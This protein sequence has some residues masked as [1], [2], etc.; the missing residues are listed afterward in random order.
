[1]TLAVKPFIHLIQDY[2]RFYIGS[3]CI[4]LIFKTS[5]GTLHTF[6]HLAQYNTLVFFLP[7]QKDAMS[8]YWSELI[9]Q[10]DRRQRGVH[11]LRR[12]LQSKLHQ[13][14]PAVDSINCWNKTR[15]NCNQVTFVFILFESSALLLPIL[16]DL[17]IFFPLKVKSWWR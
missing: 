17:L 7:Q 4:Y 13:T 5:F 1:M 8:L 11:Y 6:H 15:L 10:H 14:H 16:T 2:S 12:R 9:S 3:Y